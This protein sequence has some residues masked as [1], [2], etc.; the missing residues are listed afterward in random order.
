M[1]TKILQPVQE[2]WQHHCAALGEAI[3]H[4]IHELNNL[5]RLDDYH[6]HGHNTEKLE[7]ALG[8]YATA[9]LDVSSLSSVLGPSARALAMDSVRLDRINELLKSL[10]SMKDD[11]SLTVS[12]CESVDIEE[13]ELR[14]H[15]AAEKHLHHMASVFRA[16][17]IAQLEIRSKY[18]PEIHDVAFANFDWQ[19]LSPAELRLCPPF[20]VVA[21]INAN[22]S[23]QLRKAMSLLE[24]RQPIK[25]VTVRSDLRTQYASVHDPSVPVSMAVEMIPLAMRGV[26]FVQTCVADPQFE[27][28]LFAGLTAPRPGVVSLLSPLDHE[29]ADHFHQRAQR[30]VRSRAFPLCF[31][32]PDASR[33]FVNC[34]DLSNNPAVEDVWVNASAEAGDNGTEGD[35]YTF[36]HFAESEASFVAEFDLIAE[37][38]KPEHVIPMTDYLEL[39]RRQRVGRTPFIEVI[40]CNGET[41]QKTASDAVVV[42]TADRMHLWRTL[43]QIAGI[44]NPHIQQAHTKLHAEFGVHVDSLK[45]QMEAETTCREQTAVAEAVRRFVAHLTGVDPSEINVS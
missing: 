19:E 25:I 43:Q 13:D 27:E 39:N 8:P 4:T 35:E 40:D 41:A 45:E 38:E 17:R 16:L 21:R 11:G 36:A 37:A 12:G 18:Q 32:D 31:Y 42:Q 33:H 15:Q 34:F 24:S 7:E 26:H 2:V 28:N 10:E 23:A 1:Q 9:S 5:V 22:Q 44:D 3:T 6:R 20:I 29:E 14:I 30:A